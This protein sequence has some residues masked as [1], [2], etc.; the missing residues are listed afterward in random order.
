MI[1]K[2][3]FSFIC[4]VLVVFSGCS[5]KTIGK[6]TVNDE[7]FYNPYI[8]KIVLYDTGLQNARLWN[9]SENQFQY[10][11]GNK[12]IYV[13]GN[14]STNEFNLIKVEKSLITKI[15]E[16]PKKEGFF[17]I[18]GKD[19]KIYF[20]HSYYQENGRE[21]YNKRKLSVF[22][23][24]TKEL[25]EFSNSSGLIDYGVVGEKY[26]YYT[27]YDNEKDIYSLMKIKNTDINNYPEIIKTV[28]NDGLLLLENDELYYSDGNKLISNNKEYKKESVNVFYD[29]LLFQYYLNQ[30]NQLCVRATN[31]KN[32]IAFVEEN[33]IGIRIENN[34][35][36]ICK[37]GQVVTH[38]L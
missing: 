26:I 2:I 13:D 15:H 28:L 22:D 32:N 11:V 36:I 8:Q 29:A 12:N 18:G 16:F 5:K 38:D 20:I 31:T 6:T 9:S 23:L 21:D 7:F 17:P 37:M 25:Q 35:A 10:N 14:S 30:N 27:V 19:E 33:I 1:K 24:S 4:L 3:G 34:K